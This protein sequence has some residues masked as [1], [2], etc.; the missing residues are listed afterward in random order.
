[1]VRRKFGVTLKQRQSSREATLWQVWSKIGDLAI[2]HAVGFD[3]PDL[4]GLTLG[5]LEED[6]ALA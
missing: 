6:T 5:K 3:P 4:H 2:Y 1:L